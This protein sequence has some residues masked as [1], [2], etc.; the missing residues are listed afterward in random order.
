MRHY[1]D[2]NSEIELLGEK[3]CWKSIGNLPKANKRFQNLLCISDIEQKN[4]KPTYI[5]STNLQEGEPRV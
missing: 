5:F 1:N 4:V 2:R 3:L